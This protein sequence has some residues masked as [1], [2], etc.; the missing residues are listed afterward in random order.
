VAIPDAF[1]P[2]RTTIKIVRRADDVAGGPAWALRAW[3]GRVNPRL[4]VIGP[5]RDL[6]CFQIG[7]Q[8]GGGRLTLPRPGGGDRTLGLGEGDA[9]C[10][11]PRWLAGHA[12]GPLLRVEVDDI[13]AP[14]PRPQ[15]VVVAGL[16]G[17]G[18]RSAQLLG[19]GAPRDLDLGPDGTF[20][21]VLP[22]DQAAKALSVRQTRA[23]GTLRTSRTDGLEEPCRLTAGQ[24][25]RVADPDGGPPWA[26]G[27]SR[28]G[29]R[30]CRFVSRIVDGRIASID[31]RDGTVHFGPASWSSGAI[32]PAGRFRTPPVRLEVSGPGMGPARAE[33]SPTS[34]SQVARRTLPGRTIV[35][36][37]LRA[38][39]VSVTLRTPRDVRT[40]KPVDGIFLAVY[41]G[42]FYTGDV[43]AEA[44]LRNG[45]TLTERRPIAFP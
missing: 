8:A 12:G 27:R 40:L 23:D 5:D 34:P 4:R 28:V 14:D 13:A 39:V 20:L 7:H 24:S 3:H 26:A 11:G 45:R 18:V 22:P 30:S 32:A 17:P 42:A 36:G 44:H 37:A 6:D 43:V 21:V 19:A 25:V 2:D 10:N 31:D 33:T 38:D 35:T 15:R 1:Q 16:L 41:D 29:H 9:F